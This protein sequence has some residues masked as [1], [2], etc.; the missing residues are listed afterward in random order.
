MPQRNALQGHPVSPGLA[1]GPVHVIGDRPDAVPLWT[2]SAE[3]IEAE[4][5][6]LQG[7]IKFV[8]D[9]IGM[10]QKLL[11]AQVGEQ[12]AAIFGM[13]RVILQD[14]RAL[15]QI[16]AQIQ[17]QRINAESAVQGLIQ[18]L[19][20]T[21][22]RLEGGGA[23]GAAADF[24]EPWKRVLDAL[25]QREREAILSGDDKV[26]LAAADLTPRVATYLDRS[27]LLAIVTE[28]G[29]RFSHG[30]VLARSLG[31]PCVIGLPNLL[32]RLQ[33][34]M[35]IA[36]DGNEGRVQLAP[37]PEDLEEFHR[38]QKR[39]D[40]RRAALQAEAPLP[41]RTADGLALSVLANIEGV[42]D[43]ET[44]DL[45]SCE[46]VGLFRTEFLYMERTQFP[47]E[48]EQYRVYRRVLERMRGRPVTM[49]LLDIGG[50][51][52]LPYF[53]TPREANPALGWRGIR[54]SLEWRDLLRVQL[55][56]LLRASP[57]GDLRI[58]I[59]MVGSIHE[60]REIHAVFDQLRNE[61]QGQG[62]EV[63]ASVPVGAMIEVPSALILIEQ[64]LAEV[65]FVSV[66][67]NDLVQYLLAVDRDNAR[68]AHLYDP[69]HP[70]VLTA[71]ARIADASRAAGKRCAVCGDLAGDPIMS[72][73]LLGL[74]F[75]SVSVAP[76][77]QL[78]IK[79]AVRQ[80]GRPAIEE[81]ARSA[82][83]SRSSGDL[84]KLLSEA[85][86]HLYDRP[87]AGS[88]PGP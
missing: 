36:V 28:S 31:I 83:A 2:I 78:E 25:L 71:L 24:S 86:S 61:L 20:D 40:S 77:F 72:L 65:D 37:G 22:S 42:R 11:R 60:I 70:A 51:K 6:R 85:R 21:L 33:Q 34:D 74:G 62:Y 3:E 41:G 59:P 55:R 26:V 79:Y 29:G 68:V 46:G 13:Q 54:I 15:E 75:D 47:S 63:S 58:L 18:R 8:S 19:S 69:H 12:D 10:Q 5:Q 7:A 67:T 66:G 76:H 4:T 52:Q 9:E 45:A 53:K 88:K 16:Q 35:H 17:E 23:R 84:R 56:A 27:R 48:E 81:L 39:F 1:V 87:A 38:R 64:V 80:F 32:A 73:V 30:A 43:L 57:A 44:F 50:D 49:R 82:L 14:P